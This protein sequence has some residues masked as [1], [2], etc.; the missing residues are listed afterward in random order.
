MCT[1]WRLSYW[2]AS[3]GNR[4]SLAVEHP[5]WL[6]SSMDENL[7]D[8]LRKHEELFAASGTDD[9]SDESLAKEMFR[10][11]LERRRILAD[12][13]DGSQAAVMVDKQTLQLMQEWDSE[14][15][16]MSTL[17]KVLRRMATGR[18]VAAIELLKRA[19]TDKATALSQDQRRKAK[20][21]RQ[22]HP[23]DGMIDNELKRNPRITAAELERS[24]EKQIGRGV[25]LDMDGDEIDFV[26]GL[27]KPRKRV[28]S[29][30]IS[31]LK[32]RLTDARKR[33][34]AKAG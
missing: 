24:L 6:H 20:M 33:A 32:D 7:A 22:K 14:N 29:I 3:H 27:V 13:P 28:K 23:L 26:D 34:L 10:F 2:Q 31:G 15:P 18:E 1:Q 11:V 12:V 30:K 25:I 8:R 5:W 17:E 9:E 4:P 21:P 16:E 19:V